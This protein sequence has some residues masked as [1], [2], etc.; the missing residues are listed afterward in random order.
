MSVE[1]T[2]GDPVALLLPDLATEL[3]VTRA[4]LA[5]VPWE[6]ADW[7]PHAKSMSLGMLAGHVAQMPGFMTAMAALDVLEFSP[8]AFAAPVMNSADDLVACFDAEC[9]KLHAS[10]AGT[11]WARM[12]GNW[13][14]MAGGQAFIDNS[15]GF[16]LRH[17]GINHLVH[18]RAQLGVYLRLLDVPIPGSYGPSADA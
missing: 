2:A 6:K 7:K 8:E 1:V 13:K 5:R 4:L 10:L 3:A 11:D 15:R 14:M 16:L 17:M 12:Q 18:H 9:T